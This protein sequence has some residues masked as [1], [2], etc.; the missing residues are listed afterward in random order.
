MR[1]LLPPS[2][3]NP[4]HP[5]E[6]EAT[7]TNRYPVA[8]FNSMK[9]EYSGSNDPGD[10]DKD[11]LPESVSVVAVRPAS[12]LGLTDMDLENR[13]LTISPP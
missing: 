8:F 12:T 9:R 5:Y 11:Q 1:C 6:G 4:A 10:G 2:R 3:N 7:G 13:L